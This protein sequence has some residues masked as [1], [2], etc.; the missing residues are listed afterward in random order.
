MTEY[1]DGINPGLELGAREIVITEDWIEKYR[2]S[3]ADD[4]PWSAGAAPSRR[5]VPPRAASTS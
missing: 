5:P 2:R 1:A 4:T 3:I